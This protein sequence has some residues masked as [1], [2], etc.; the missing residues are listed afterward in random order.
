MHTAC[1]FA[2]VSKFAIEVFNDL[3]IFVG[4]LRFAL[5]SGIP[6]VV[7]EELVINLW[8]GVSFLL[9]SFNVHFVFT[10]VR[11]ILHVGIDDESTEI[12]VD[13]FINFILNYTKNIKSREDRVRKI[14][15]LLEL[16]LWVVSSL[17]RIGCCDD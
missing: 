12:V 17:E 7:F 11:V 15:V 10:I 14:D 16:Q 2:C 5:V 3:K 1:F 4:K 9:E 13:F 6:Y 8:F